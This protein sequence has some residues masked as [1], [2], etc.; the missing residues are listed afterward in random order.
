MAQSTGIPQLGLG[1]FGRTGPGG[2][3]AIDIAIEIGYRHL[4]TAQDYGT[5]A[6]VG[7]AIRES[8][9]KRDAFFVTTKVATG[10]LGAGKLVP[11]IEKSLAVS[12]LDRFDL[13]LIHWPSPDG[14]PPSVY[15]PELAEAK[16]RGLTRLIGVSNFTIPLIE[17]AIGILGAGALATN[18]VELHPYLQN[19]KLASFCDAHDIAVICYLPIAKNRIANDPVMTGI[20]AAHDAAP[21]QVALAFLLAKGYIAIP[22]SGSRTHLL[23]N[24]AARQLS[25]T[26]ADIARIEGLDRGTRYIDPAWGPDWD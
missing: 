11:S 26:A 21:A 24:F 3:A 5:E 6:N 19:R 17:D 10:N 23:S 2:R 16:A 25:L 1:T 9:L 15:L 20:A 14:V 13:V 22:A 7:A 4:D 18:Q 8:G 12:G